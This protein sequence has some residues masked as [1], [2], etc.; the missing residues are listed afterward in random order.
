[1]ALQTPGAWAGTVISTDGDGVFVTV[2]QEKWDKAKRMVLDTMAEMEAG[3]GWV[4][5]KAL[6]R[7]RGF[8]LYVTR[9]Y[10]AMVPYLKGVHLT[11]DGWRKG[12]DAEGWKVT[13]WEARE[14][15]ANGE[16]TGKDQDLKGPKN[17]KAKPRLISDLQALM[18]LLAAATPPNQRIR[19]KNLVEVYYGFG[20]ASQDGFGFNIQIGDRIVPVRTVVRRNFRKVFELQGA[21]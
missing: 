11:L 12:R 21:T 18:R 13:N 8:L 17:V 2:L 5:H 9:T 3:Q 10:P 6:E 14:A 15:W 19:S 20:D 1:M 4:D 7:R 16:D